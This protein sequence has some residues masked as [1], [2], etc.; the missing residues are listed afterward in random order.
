MEPETQPNGE[1]Q[2][3]TEPVGD[4]G[5]GVEPQQETTDG[6]PPTEEQAQPGQDVPRRPTRAERR[7]DWRRNQEL[8]RALGA[9]T[10]QNRELN[11]RLRE[12]SARIAESV[13]ASRPP[14]EDPLVARKK[15]LDAQ[16]QKVLARLDR[17]PSAVE[18][19]RDLQV[20]YGKLG[21]EMHDAKK[22]PP[23]RGPSPLGQSLAAEFPWLHPE[24]A[25]RDA[26]A[27]VEGYAAKLAR[28]EKRNM[29]D[30]NVLYTTLRQAAALV[31]KD[32]GYPL[33]SS[34]SA[35]GDSNGRDR[36]SG[37]SG[38]GGVGGNAG[39]DYAG[40]E[41]DIEAAATVMYPQLD[42]A[43]AVNKWKSTV[44]KSL[45]SMRK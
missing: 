11:E 22:A 9:M 41:P 18:E 37:S 32:L 31:A 45:A 12:M 4:P 26:K 14:R 34:F 39:P 28:T 23:P 40:L 5:E 16:Y 15:T 29:S 33:P 20:E 19:F 2:A 8:N 35:G 10:T 44:G 7:E 43:A 13:E 27:M 1:S 17:D 6:Q 38:R 30:P 21:A 3:G 25:D 36:M 24:S 42:R